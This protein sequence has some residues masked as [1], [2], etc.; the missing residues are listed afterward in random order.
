MYWNIAD[1]VLR[2][3]LESYYALAA[4]AARMVQDKLNRRAGLGLKA[5]AAEMPQGRVDGILN[6][7][8]SG[9]YED[10]SWILG[11]PLETFCRAAVDDTLK[12]NLEF[13][14]KAGLAARIIRKTTGRKCCEVCSRLAGTYKYPEDTWDVEPSVFWRHNSCRCVVEYDPGDGKGMRQNVHTKKWTSPEERAILEKRK[15]FGLHPSANDENRFTKGFTRSNLS[16]HFTKH[17]D[18]YP[19]IKSAKEYNDCALKLIQSATSDD[20]LGYRT[21]DGAVVRYRMSTNDFVKGYPETGI[22]AMFRP[23][24]DPSSGLRY[25]LKLREK[26]GITD[27]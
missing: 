1:R 2:P 25:F 23:K 4:E 6:V 13:Q 24:K 9:D 15:T 22:A 8:T 3:L 27:D 26:E 11:E 14:S 12:A 17:T 16:S 19:E 21:S 5:V 7:V 18:E 10:T 20:I